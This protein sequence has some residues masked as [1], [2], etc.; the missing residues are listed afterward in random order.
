[1]PLAAPVLLVAERRSLQLS[2]DLRVVATRDGAIVS[3]FKGCFRLD[4]HSADHFVSEILPALYA[5]SGASTA[6]AVLAIE[7][8][9]LNAGIC[10]AIEGSPRQLPQGA[11][12]PRISFH[13]PTPLSLKVAA[14][15]TSDGVEVDG[16]N[17]GEGDF[18][19]SDL[20][21]LPDD[22][23]FS[24]V[25]DLHS[26]RCAAIFIWKHGDETFVG[27]LTIPGKTACW[28]CAHSRLLDSLGEGAEAALADAAVAQVVRDNV[29]LGL[30]FPGV[31]GYG[32]LVAE[33]KSS[34]VHAILPVPWCST[35]GGPQDAGYAWINHSIVVP[36]PTRVL[37]DPRAGVIRQLLV[38]DGTANDLPAV[39][40]CA[41]ALI[42]LP[43]TRGRT[44]DFLRG[45]GKGATS[46]EAILGA[47]GEGLERYSASLWNP[48]ALVQASPRELGEQVFALDF[49]VLYSAEQYTRPGFEF[50][51]VDSDSRM[52]WVSGR[53]LDTG[54]E[55]LL[56][57]QASYLGF[58]DEV[59]LMQGT[60][61]GLAA[62]NSFED[63]ALRATY[64]L[65]E[66]DAF[67]LYWLAGMSAER[68]DPAGSD[69]VSQKALYEAARLGAKMELYLL[70]LVGVP[71]VACLGF[72]DGL[73]W[74]GVTIGLGTHVNIDIAVRKA[75]L[76]HGHFGPY[77]RRL[78]QEGQHTRVRQPHD[79]LGSL[80]HGLYYCHPTNA[81]ELNRLR[82][83][84]SSSR[85]AQVR[86]RYPSSSSLAGCVDRLAK[87]GIRIAAVDLTTPDVAL[88]GLRVVRAFGTF[89]Q[90]IHFGFGNERV[91]SPRLRA[92]LNEPV[93][94]VPHP[95]A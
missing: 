14:L 81:V 75:V 53:W 55:V 17:A 50:A 30:R 56:P 35:C 27:P 69:E 2:R 78:M 86:E 61:N 83:Q 15:L 42:A 16:P 67:M 92:L 21:S 33:G 94:T 7:K 54:D 3:T 22:A 18:V 62:G 20:S 59:P 72:G 52:H 49:L 31:A 39:P 87:S 66:R 77:M 9:L 36:R 41:S 10:V 19:I 91:A 57:A 12:R 4:R 1:M 74:P 60:S 89:A 84:S 28:R 26:R 5:T 6:D 25:D 48:A 13:V 45:E 79:V 34:A 58:R 47:I 71:T 93:R 51:P 63:A 44:Q 11:R 32:C 38:F 29:I 85:L 64:E 23:A 65:V 8:S 76:E 37:A 68:L 46:G 80:D 73:A 88:T 24:I 40:A 70:D 82:S 43:G 90:P 95:M